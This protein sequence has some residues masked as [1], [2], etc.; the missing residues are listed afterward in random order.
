MIS[1]LNVREIDRDIEL[2]GSVPD[3]MLYCGRSSGFAK[4]QQLVPEL[5]DC[6]F[7]GN[8]SPMNY[9]SAR[10][11]VCNS[12]RANVLWPAMK[13]NGGN[14][15]KKAVLR[16]VELDDQGKHIGLCCFCKP[17][18]CHC[19]DIVRAVAWVKP[20][21]VEKS[22]PSI[23]EAYPNPWTPEQQLDDNELKGYVAMG[24]LV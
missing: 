16:L 6:S 4:A 15:I 5:V 24:G 11:R 3:I 22:A 8:P 19:D 23:D 9:E 20:V 17:K 12:F 21:R 14:R 13:S 2:A 18:R 10:D 1:V 7:L